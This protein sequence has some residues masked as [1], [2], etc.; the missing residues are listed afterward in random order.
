MLTATTLRQFNDSVLSTTIFLERE[1]RA[2]LV[3]RDRLVF[4]SNYVPPIERTKRVAH[5]YLQLDGHFAIQG[6]PSS[7]S[8]VGYLLHEDEFDC[9]QPGAPRFR[10][11]GTPGVILEVRVPT[12]YLRVPIGIAHGPLPLTDAVW[13]ACT[14]LRETKSEQSVKR[15]L[16]ALADCGVFEHR[17]LG[18]IVDDEPERFARLWD[19][20]RPLYGEMAV[21]SSLKQIAVLTKLSLRQLGRDLSDLTRTFGLLGGGFREA[22]R[23]LRLRAAVLILSAPGV[24]PSEVA[25]L[26]GYGS[27]DAMGRAFRDATLPAPSVVQAAVRYPSASAST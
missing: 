1:L 3:H 23:V 18:T 13:N 15:V 20:L 7:T 4:D 14:E 6:Q 9:V 8:P 19:V 16:A 17:L 10:S 5:I 22:M 24:T 25:K 27:L 21:S 11:W 12:D 2:H 26:V